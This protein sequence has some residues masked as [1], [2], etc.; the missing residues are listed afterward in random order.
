MSVY[1]ALSSEF[2]TLS[3]FYDADR[4]VFGGGGWRKGGVIIENII[5]FNLGINNRFGMGV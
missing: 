5:W 4:G 2:C 1:F 3:G